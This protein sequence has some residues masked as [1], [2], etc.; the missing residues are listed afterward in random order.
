VIRQGPVERF[1]SKVEAGPECWIWTAATHPKGY[2]Q[3]GYDKR[4]QPAHRVAWQLEHGAIP[5]DYVVHH[6]CHVRSCV[7]PK[8]LELVTRAKHV[9]L[10]RAD[11]SVN[12]KR[13]GRKGKKRL[14]GL[15]LGVSKKRHKF[16]ARI[17]VAGQE[18][19][20]GTF[21]SAEEAHNAYQEARKALGL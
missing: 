16:R 11:Y 9:A 12:G 1:W 4:T 2:G 21:E 8:H 5:E 14:N 17:V 6:K 3:F 10:H 15:P 7:N 18:T 13:N 20:L 19:P